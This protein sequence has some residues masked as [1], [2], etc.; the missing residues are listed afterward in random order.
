MEEITEKKYLDDL[1]TS[2]FESR[3]KK[4][5]LIPWIKN[6]RI[7]ELGC[8]SGPIL[9]LMLEH[10]KLNRNII[11]A[12]DNSEFML[13]K[14]KKYMG[15]HENIRYF[16]VDFLTI[17]LLE[18]TFD[19]IISSSS[20]HEVYSSFSGTDDDRKKQSLQFLDKCYCSLKKEGRFIVYTKIRP[21]DFEVEIK[22]LNKKTYEKYEF[23]L[24]QFIRPVSHIPLGDYQVRL[25]FKDAIEFLEKYFF[26]RLEISDE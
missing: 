10:N 19:S 23:F 15:V 24:K 18:R 14:A 13:D 1:A 20:F 25:C 9:K 3:H 17:P 6:G 5:F 4:S 7:L 11:Y 21:E 2:L 12:V 26:F 16:L 22:F 8:G